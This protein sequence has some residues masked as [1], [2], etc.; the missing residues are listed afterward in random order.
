ML[1]ALLVPYLFSPTLSLSFTNIREAR[2]SLYIGI[3]NSE[4]DFLKAEKACFKKIVPV[5]STGTLRLEAVNLPPGTY[6]ISCFHDLNGNG[7]LDTNLFGIPSEPY[8][9]SNNA[10]PKFRAPKWE[11]AKFEVKEGGKGMEIR[12]EKW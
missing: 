8:G 2:G 5:G 9:F 12:L 6:A 1:F 3:Y 4:A 11:E 10:R 7:E